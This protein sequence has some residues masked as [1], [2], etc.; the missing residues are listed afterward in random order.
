MHAVRLA[1]QEFSLLGP[2]TAWL[3]QWLV[4]GPG[5]CV[6]ACSEFLGRFEF[7]KGTGSRSRWA[8]MACFADHYWTSNQAQLGFSK[9]S[10]A[11]ERQGQP[12]RLR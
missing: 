3:T 4:S 9:G 8:I 12:G 7:P 6:P 10:G 5:A 1:C 2:G 11:G